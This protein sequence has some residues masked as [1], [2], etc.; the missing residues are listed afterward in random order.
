MGGEGQAT[1]PRSEVRHRYGLLVVDADWPMLV[2]NGY[3]RFSYQPRQATI[4]LGSIYGSGPKYEA[5][6]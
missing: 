2:A 3:T 1:G 6:R 5:K 4:V